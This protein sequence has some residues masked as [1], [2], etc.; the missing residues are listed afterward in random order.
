MVKKKAKG[1]TYYK[2]DNMKLI[3][4]TSLQ[5]WSIPFT[6]PEGLQEIYITPKETIKVPA[7]YI[8]EYVIRYQK[9]SLI[10]VKN[11]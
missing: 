1:S 5:S 6:T 9:R 4:N 2:R 7:S 8:N 3:T 10:S 11:A